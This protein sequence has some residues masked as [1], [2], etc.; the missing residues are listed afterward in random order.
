LALKNYDGDIFAEIVANGLGVHGLMYNTLVTKSGAV[1]SETNHGTISRH[2]ED[3][4]KGGDL[5]SNPISTIYAWTE[6]LRLRAVHDRNNKLSKFVTTMRA[7]VHDVVSQGIVTKD[8]A[9][10]IKRNDHVALGKDFV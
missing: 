1:L 8:I 2:Y 5:I 3:W 6:A 7:A 4:Q 10:A 9:M